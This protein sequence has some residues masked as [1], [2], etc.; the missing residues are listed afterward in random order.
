MATPRNVLEE[1]SMGITAAGERLAK[2]KLA[3]F[4]RLQPE[5][6]ASFRLSGSKGVC[7]WAIVIS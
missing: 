1:V 7:L 5:F 4:E 2:Q 3:A 6:E